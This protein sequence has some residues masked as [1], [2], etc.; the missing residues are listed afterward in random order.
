MIV[1]SLK[2]TVSGH[3]Y[4]EIL[5]KVKFTVSE[6]FEIPFED[7]H[8]KINMEIKVSDCTNSSS[9][10]EEDEFVAEVI[11]QVTNV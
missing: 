1:T 5:N 4:E 9:F 11:A 7:L 2:T 3:N 6:F 8:K 10:D